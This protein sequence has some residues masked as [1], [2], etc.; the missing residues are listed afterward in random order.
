MKEKEGLPA[1][2]VI[3]TIVSCLCISFFLDLV[4]ISLGLVMA[5]TSMRLLMQHL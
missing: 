1:I 4:F 3:G 2:A 5:I